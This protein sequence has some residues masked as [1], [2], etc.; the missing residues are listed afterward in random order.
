[1]DD[2]IPLEDSKIAEAIPTEGNNYCVDDVI[3]QAKLQADARVG[4]STTWQQED[5]TRVIYYFFILLFYMILLI[6]CLM[7]AHY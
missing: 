7:L 6:S 1:V 2:G 3:S 4:S 5:F